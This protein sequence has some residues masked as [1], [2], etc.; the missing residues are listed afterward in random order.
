MKK[1]SLKA[2][3]IICS[4][5]FGMG[6]IINLFNGSGAAL[7]PNLLQILYATSAGFMFVMM[8]LKTD[9]LL[10]CISAHG[11]FNAL[12]VFANDA[13]ATPGRQILTAVLLTVI[14]G[15]YGVYL[16]R[17]MKGTRYERI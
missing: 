9:S 6:H 4:V 12:S 15:G 13:D 11:I 7:L 5:T 14:T 2:A 3:I 16:A 17:T 10:G 1:D 8:Y